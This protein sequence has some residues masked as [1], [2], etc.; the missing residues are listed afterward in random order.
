MNK[1]PLELPKR[2]AGGPLRDIALR[3]GDIAGALRELAG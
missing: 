1:F 2:G 3:L